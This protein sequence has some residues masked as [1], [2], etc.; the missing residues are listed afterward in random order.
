VAASLVVRWLIEISKVRK[1]SPM[2]EGMRQEIVDV[3]NSTDSM[4]KEGGNEPHGAGR[5]SCCALCLVE[6]RDT[7]GY[8]EQEEGENAS[9]GRAVLE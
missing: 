2:C 1:A 5:S 7:K 8:G 3:C 6:M 4:E 9:D